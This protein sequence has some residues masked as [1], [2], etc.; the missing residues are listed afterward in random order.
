MGRNMVSD[1]VDLG[2]VEIRH[3]NSSVSGPKFIRFFWS[4]V[5][6]IVDENAVVRLSI[7]SSVLEIFAIKV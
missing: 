3:I 4:D 1:I 2:W 7:A 6:G 5:E